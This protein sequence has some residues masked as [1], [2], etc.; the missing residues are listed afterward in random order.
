MAKIG[1]RSVTIYHKE[2][3]RTFEYEMLYNSDHLF[4]AVIPSE[5]N[6]AFDH[7]NETELKE[8]S[9]KKWHK[10]KYNR[11]SNYT[12]IV[13]AVN[14]GTCEAAMKKFIEA[15]MDSELKRRNVIVLF[16]NGKDECNYGDH[17]YNGE[18]P[19][20]GFQIGLTYCVETTLGEKKVYNLF[21]EE[22]D[23]DG[24]K[25]TIRKEIRIINYHTTI[26][27]DT[28]KNR[29][30]LENIYAKLGWLNKQLK[31]FTKTEESLLGLIES[32]QKL[33]G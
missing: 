9:V 18:H 10:S 11:E 33:L 27:D 28:P 31:E 7:L 2:M 15:V 26:I 23:L 22:T 29:E 25:R 5:F 4:H 13:H 14:E 19:Q 16:Y 8:L 21:R 3:K 12:R 6:D 1:K 20:I 17:Q 24:E 30:F 32:N